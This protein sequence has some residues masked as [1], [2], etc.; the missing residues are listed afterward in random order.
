[1]L[2]VAVLPADIQDRDAIRTVLQKARRRFPF[3]ERIFADTG[4]AGEKAAAAVA[5]TGSWT[6]EIVKRCEAHRFVVRPKRWIV[7]RTLAW[8]SRNRRLARDFE[9]YARTAAAFCIL[10]MIRLMLRRLAASPSS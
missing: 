2:S 5:A 1:M 6:L 4:Y 8:I 7:E 10:A 9:R 3:I